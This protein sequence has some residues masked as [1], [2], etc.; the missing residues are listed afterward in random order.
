MLFTAEIMSRNQ[1]VESNNSKNTIYFDY[2]SSSPTNPEILQAYNDKV[3]NS[4]ANPSSPH[5]LAFEATHQLDEIKRETARILNCPQ[6]K[7]ILTSGATEANNLA[8]KGV[9]FHY[10]NRGKHLITAVNEHPSVLE[11]FR[12]LEQSFGFEVT[13]LPINEQGVINLNDLIA[14][15]KPSTIFVSLMAVNN[16]TGAINP[17]EAIAAEIKKHPKIIFHVDAVQAFGKVDLSYHNIDMF[18]ITAHK[19]GGLKGCAGLFLKKQIKLFPLLCGGGQEEGMRSGTNDLAAAYA[20]MR[21]LK[22]ASQNKNENIKKIN[23][24]IF[25]YL[26]KHS[27]EFL[28]NS[29]MC[30]LN[31]YI[32]NFSLKKKK[33]SVV[34]E[35]LSLRGFMVSTKSSCHS[36]T[37]EE[38]YVIYAQTSDHYRAQNSIR[39]SFSNDNTEE[40][41]QAF[42]QSLDEIIKEI[43]Q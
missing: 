2:A 23:R 43:K 11:T 21:A 29:A 6:H 15:I 42:I 25:D 7:L 31:P 5:R 36:R 22:V 16:E 30:E 10:Q 17:I 13:Y 14:T 20:F 38:S 28:I 24:I 33:A 19:L 9:A 32:L 18:T 37:S 3:K 8:I 27:D 39:L 41:A 35:A 12:Q 26:S 40:E 1:V 4:F 34:V